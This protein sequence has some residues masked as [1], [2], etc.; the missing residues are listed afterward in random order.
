M[1]KKSKIGLVLCVI[2][3]MCV[4]AIYDYYGMATRY[5]ASKP[6]TDVTTDLP[7]PFLLNPYK[8]WSSII[9]CFI[10]QNRLI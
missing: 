7:F 10:F 1:N 6:P 2:C 8:L 3:V 4:K 5:D 9:F